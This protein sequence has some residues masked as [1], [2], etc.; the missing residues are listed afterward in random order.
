MHE[1]GPFEEHRFSQGL[2]RIGEY[3]KRFAP[4]L[5]Q[6]I[7]LSRPVALAKLGLRQNDGF[8]SRI[9]P[10]GEGNR[11]AFP[12]RQHEHMNFR[13]SAHLKKPGEK[14]R[15]EALKPSTGTCAFVGKDGS[16]SVSA[17]L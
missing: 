2:E 1:P 5:P 6:F 9:P 13:L 11:I 3:E 4:E 10:R 12:A 15:A 16:G 17:N 8:A 14:I 7:K